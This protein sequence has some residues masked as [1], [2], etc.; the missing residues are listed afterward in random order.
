LRERQ[1]SGP[2]SKTQAKI[3]KVELRG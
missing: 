1:S 3:R 2:A